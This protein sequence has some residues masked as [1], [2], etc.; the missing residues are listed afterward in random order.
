VAPSIPLCDDIR[1]NDYVI[2]L[3][4]GTIIARLAHYCLNI[5]RF[6]S[7][8]QCY[9]ELEFDEITQTHK[10]VRMNVITDRDHNESL[11]ECKTIII[12][13]MEAIDDIRSMIKL[14]EINLFVP[15]VLNSSRAL[16]DTQFAAY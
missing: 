6:R 11:G 2:D 3:V 14:H 16:I 10:D 8:S 5:E 9:F 12:K 4:I 1:G 15:L 13:Y 7:Q